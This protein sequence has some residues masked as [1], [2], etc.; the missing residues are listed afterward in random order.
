[1][2]VE[3]VCGSSQPDTPPQ[4]V[5]LPPRTTGSG[6]A[7][8]VKSPPSASATALALG[9]SLGSRRRPPHS[10]LWHVAE[11]A[12]S[13]RWICRVLSKLHTLVKTTHTGDL[14]IGQL[15]ISTFILAYRRTRSEE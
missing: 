8:T 1:M 7:E 15:W 3:A 5:R 4:P 10:T 13:R 14:P 11:S 9:Q 12:T 6:M 2:S